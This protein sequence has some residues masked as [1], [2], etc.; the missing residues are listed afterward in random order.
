MVQDGVEVAVAVRDRRGRHALHP[1]QDVHPDLCRVVVAAPW[2]FSTG[3]PGAVL[4]CLELN[5][6]TL[7]PDR[8]TEPRLVRE[9]I[10][11]RART[12]DAIDDVIDDAS[13]R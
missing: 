6:R 11:D 5:D 2:Q 3:D 12:C 10:R 4:A 8:E 1:A 7:L 9:G 13:A